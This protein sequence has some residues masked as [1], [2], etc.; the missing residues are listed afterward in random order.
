MLPAEQTKSEVKM[1]KINGNITA[2]IQIFTSV[3]NEIGEY[4]K[5]WETVQTVKGFLDMKS[6]DSKYQNFDTKLEEST[7]LFLADYIPL[8]GITSE[9]SRMFIKGKVY[10]IMLID[11]VMELNEHYEIYLKLTGGV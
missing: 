11:N 4:E 10:D 2:E 5:L 3:E 8:D 7:H 1:K 9:N 6:G